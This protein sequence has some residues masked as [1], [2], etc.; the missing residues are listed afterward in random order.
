MATTVVKAAGT[1]S[2][3]KSSAVTTGVIVTS[4]TFTGNDG[5][6]L[7]RYSDA[8]LGGTALTWRSFGALNATDVMKIS[9]GVAKSG[10]TSGAVGLDFETQDIAVQ[11]KISSFDAGISDS[12]NNAFVD[13][14]RVVGTSK[15]FRLGLSQSSINVFYR[16][17]ANTLN[18]LGSFSYTMGDTILFLAKGSNIK[19]YINGKIV[20]NVNHSYTV[21]KG[22]F[23]L[24]HGTIA[25]GLSYTLDDLVVYSL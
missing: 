21:E 15:A 2:N 12:N 11:F 9:S 19:C 14:R 18:L 25:S 17:T 20:I 4:D 24:S 23:S 16:D 8:A 6:I 10:N 3:P 13:L 7:G 5:E 22:Y 1:I